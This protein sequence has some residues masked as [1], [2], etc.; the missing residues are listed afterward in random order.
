MS[1]G[2]IVAALGGS[3][4]AFAASGAR[5]DMHPYAAAVTE[6]SRR[7]GVPELW[8]RRVMHAES[9]GNPRAVSHAGAMGVMQIMPATWAMLSKRHHLGAD[10]FD[11]RSNVLAGA[12]YLRAMWDRYR[13]VALMLAAY[14]AGPGRVDAYV[15]GRGDLPVETIAYVARIAPE[16]GASGLASRAAAPIARAFDW[17]RSALFSARDDGRSTDHNRAA[18]MPSDWYPPGVTPDSALPDSA[19]PPSLFVHLS[20]GDR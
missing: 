5:A 17:R 2:A 20:G 16:L 18:I 13:D 12:A 11:V 10:P 4:A 6:A 8:I 15:S 19:V 14:N 1:S 9:R 7:F 3:S